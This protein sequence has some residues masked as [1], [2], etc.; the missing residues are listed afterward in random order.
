[1]SELNE[2]DKELVEKLVSKADQTKLKYRF[3]D[4]FQRRIL[5]LVLTDNT[6]LVQSRSLIEPEYFT[7]EAHVL[8]CKVQKRKL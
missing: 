4:N 6:F 1:M 2:T 7:S 5:S 3:D 8:I